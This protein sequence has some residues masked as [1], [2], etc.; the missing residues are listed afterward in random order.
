MSTLHHV[1]DLI[2]TLLAALGDGVAIGDHVLLRVP[3][4]MTVA[5]ERTPEP[6]R[7]VLAFTP[8]IELSTRRGPFH[9]RCTLS[10]ATIGPD[11]IRLA[12]D[13]WFDRRWPVES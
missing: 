5:V 9:L 7:A 10:A 12:I 8:P 6:A 13:G 2:E 4:G 1:R 3:P 11:E